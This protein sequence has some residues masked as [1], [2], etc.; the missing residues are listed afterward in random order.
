MWIAPAEP[1]NF[2][3]LSA[4]VSSAG[5]RHRDQ[6]HTRLAQLA[7]IKCTTPLEH[8]VRVHT[9]GSRHFGYAGAGFSVNCTI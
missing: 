3:C 4:L 1:H 7:T 6:R 9:M 2:F 8:L 5:H